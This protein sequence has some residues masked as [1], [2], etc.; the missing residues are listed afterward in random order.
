[1]RHL[2][3]EGPDGGGKSR[4]AEALLARYPVTMHEKASHSLRG[5]VRNLAAWVTDDIAKMDHFETC[6]VY[7]RHPII[8]EPIYG[9]ITRQQPQPGFAARRDGRSD[10][11]NHWLST[12]RLALYE[13]ATI[14]W[15]IPSLEQ[16]RAAVDPTRDMPGVVENIDEI[17]ARYLMTMAAWGGSGARYDLTRYSREVTEDGLFQGAL[18]FLHHYQDVLRGW[19][20]G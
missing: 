4:L 18:E 12:Q 7:D 6:N 15:C 13:K 8:S 9:S 2:I 20:N 5:P 11:T 14:I 16:C 10:G 3:L 19:V 17:H 1:M